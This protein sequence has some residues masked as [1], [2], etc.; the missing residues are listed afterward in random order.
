MRSQRRPT[1]ALPLGTASQL[2]AAQISVLPEFETALPFRRERWN[3]IQAFA[4]HIL[5]GYGFDLHRLAKSIR[6]GHCELTTVDRAIFALT[7]CG[8]TPISEALREQLWHTFS[9]PLYEMII[10]PGSTVLAAECELH[11][12]WHLQEGAEA[13][14]LK[15]ELVY[16]APPLTGTHTGFTCDI[17][18]EPCDCGRPTP[19]LKNLTPFLPRPYENRIAAVA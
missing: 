7:D 19:R 18:R 13:Y 1:L 16:D 15:G 11:N 10:A 6:D 17:D 4:P 9:V 14:L 3:Q 5:I 8:S 2:R 12:G